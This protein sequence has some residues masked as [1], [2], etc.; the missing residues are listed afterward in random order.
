MKILWAFSELAASV[1][2]VLALLGNNFQIATYSMA[3][4]IYSNLCKNEY[5]KND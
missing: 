4:A 2:A 3:L 1:V 5:K